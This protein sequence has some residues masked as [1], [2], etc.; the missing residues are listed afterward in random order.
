MGYKAKQGYVVYRVRIRRGGRKKPVPK[1][2]EV[3]VIYSIKNYIRKDKV[4]ILMFYG[5][6]H[7]KTY[8]IK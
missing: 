3:Y 5:V 4:F 1:V 7:L 6:R 2:N 8:K